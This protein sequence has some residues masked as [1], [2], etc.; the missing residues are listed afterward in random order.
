MSKK[1]KTWSI[2]DLVVMTLSLG[3]GLCGG[4]VLEIA[5]VI[6]TK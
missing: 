4:S 6:T 1:I 5:S 2:T 3:V